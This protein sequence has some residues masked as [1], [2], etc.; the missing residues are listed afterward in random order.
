MAFDL[1]PSD[2]DVLTGIEGINVVR[3]P[4]IGV[5]FLQFAITN[6][7]VAD[8]RDP[9]GDL[10]RVRPQ[11]AA[12][13]RVPGRRPAAL[14]AARVRC[15]RPGARPLRVR[16]GEGQGAHRRGPGRRA[17]TRPRRCASSTSQN[18][19]GW[20][21]IAAA[22]ENDLTER[23]SQPGRSSRRTAPAGRPSCPTST[24]YEISLQCCGS[25]FH[26][27]R[28]SAHVQLR[29]AHRD[30]L[31]ELR[32]GRAVRRRPRD[33]RPGR[34]GG[35]LRSRSRASSTRTCPTTGCGPWR[36]RTPTTRRWA[37]SST[38]PTHA[39]RSPRSRSGR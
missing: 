38:T 9:P 21:D 12:R 32:D 5:Q 8:K 13:D 35:P 11:D 7:L 34:A 28:T 20:D 36:T 31:R 2:F 6:P 1:V 22:V 37:A 17:S 3:V 39:S 10:L 4:G 19:P 23:R 16:P 26:P 14:G 33:R 25:F 27:D 18:E 15:Q 29:D 24:T 30:A